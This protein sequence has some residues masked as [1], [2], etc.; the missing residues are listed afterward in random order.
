MLFLCDK[1][2]EKALFIPAKRKKS[3]KNDGGG[4]ISTKTNSCFSVIF[5][6]DWEDSY[7]NKERR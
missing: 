3:K 1:E 7:R 6:S 2:H 5:Q 4:D